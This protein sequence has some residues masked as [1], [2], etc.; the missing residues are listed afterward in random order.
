MVA[1][2]GLLG[3]RSPFPWAFATPAAPA[4]KGR[5]E[6]ALA[7]VAGLLLAPPVASA[8]EL[9]PLPPPT[10]KD[11]AQSATKIQ[12]GVDWL[13]FEI[14]PALVEKSFSRAKSAVGSAGEGAFV[15]PLQ[16]QLMFPLSQILS[17]NLDAEEDGWNTA[18]KDINTAIED[19]KEKISASEF[20]DAL[21]AWDRA[22]A[23]TNK[24]LTNI[25][26]RFDGKPPF[27]LLDDTY[28]APERAALYT[29]AKKDSIKD[30]NAAGAGGAML[31][32]LR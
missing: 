22:R 15:S 31:S 2:Q 8:E 1:L 12:K 6:A 10:Q 28:D 19:M 14:K 13:Y 32:L 26:E 4:L 27:R 11:V 24:I 29:K 23:S 5:R 25:N 21:V 16:T 18:F 9:E 3:Q 17:S 7:S 20:E 30:R